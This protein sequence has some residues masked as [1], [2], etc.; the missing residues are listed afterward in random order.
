MD[1]QETQSRKIIM[2]CSEEFLTFDKKTYPS[3]LQNYIQKWEWEKIAIEATRIIGTAY[4]S[5]KM[6][7]NI[8]VPKFFDILFWCML[9]LSF[10]SFVFII[11]YAKTKSENEA[12]FYI[13]L[14]L[15]S[16]ACAVIIILMF[17]NYF[18]TLPEEKNIFYF[19]SEGMKEYIKELNEKYENTAI[20]DYNAEKLQI[21]CI[22]KNVK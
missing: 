6:Q 13:G 20:F 19:I 14:V 18:R 7:E 1:S 15:I 2:K 21:E 17:Y 22:L 5:R 9:L 16:I 12:L 4:H 11:V 3:I 8:N 10:I